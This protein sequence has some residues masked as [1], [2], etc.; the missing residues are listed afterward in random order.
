MIMKS[1]IKHINQWLNGRN[2][3]LFTVV[4][5]MMQNSLFSQA[6][7]EDNTYLKAV[8]EAIFKRPKTFTSIDSLFY[9]VKRDTLKMAYLVSKSKEANYPEGQS[10]ALN[11]LGIYFRNKSYFDRAIT[12]HLQAEKLAIESNN[13]DLHI[14]SLNMLGVV[15]RR[16]ESVKSA[17]D[18]HQQ[19]LSIA[20]TVKNRTINIIKSIAVSQNSMGNIYLALEQYDLAIQQFKKSLAIEKSV[21]NK[22][23]LAINYHN[24]GYAEEA[25]GFLDEALENYQIS[26]DYNNQIDSKV[27]KVICNNSI[28]QIYLKQGN[29]PEAYKI[30]SSTITPAEDIDDKF[31]IASTYTNLGWV[32]TE[33]KQYKKAGVNLFHALDVAQEYKLRGSEAEAYQRLSYLNEKLGKNKTALGQYKKYQDISNETKSVKN[34]QY[35]TELVLK[36]DAEKKSEQIKDLASENEIIN[37]KLAQNKK[38]LWFTLIGLLLLSGVLFGYYKQRQLKKDKKILMLEQ[39]MLRAQMNPHFIFNSLNSIKLYIINNEKENAVYYL[40]KFSKLIRKILVASTEKEISLE[41]ELETMQLY[42]NIENIRFNNDINYTVDVAENVNTNTIKLPSLILQPFLEN[43]LWHGL[44]SKEGDKNIHLNVSRTDTGFVRMEITDN[45]IGRAKAGKIQENKIL[46]RK[47]VGIALTKQRLANFS[48]DYSG[49]YNI[50]IQDLH[51]DGKPSGTKVVI[52]IPVHEVTL[53]TA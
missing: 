4:L 43:A 22:L 11:M 21:D 34:T 53:Q 48:S 26:L 37:L 44:S 25:T 29:I 20:D 7:K 6:S 28:G 30:I 49:S 32:Q 27:G 52:D 36:Y 23:G 31:Y 42:M 12:L 50:D 16:M 46:K 51:Q 14:T 1:F 8:E 39:D 35:I 3:F 47:S 40:N 45:G 24:I 33:M 13:V 15:Y 10:Y 2:L 9:D 38:T 18:Y 5:F 41:D 17:L 19:A